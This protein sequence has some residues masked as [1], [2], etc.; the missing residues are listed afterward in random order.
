MKP[1]EGSVKHK[2][3]TPRQLQRLRRDSASVH[4]DSA[5][6]RRGQGQVTLVQVGRVAQGVHGDEL[7]P[8]PKSQKE[9]H[10]SRPNSQ[11]RRRRFKGQN[12]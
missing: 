11:V 2:E 1:S 7:V 8:S 3:C 6:V 9:K 5:S 12:L 4:K 10:K